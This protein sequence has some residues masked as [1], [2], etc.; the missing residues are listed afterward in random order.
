MMLDVSKSMG[1]EDVASSRLDLAK[2]FLS[3]YVQQKPENRYGLGVFAG[4][5]V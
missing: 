2:Q 4:E 5:S 3:A 1:V